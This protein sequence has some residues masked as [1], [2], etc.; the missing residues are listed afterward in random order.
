MSKLEIQ[1]EATFAGEW[2]LPSEDTSQ[3]KDIAG[4]LTWEEV[5]ARLELH[6]S[7]TP[8]RSGPIGGK[9]HRVLAIHG[10]TLKST[11]VSM[12]DAWC[13][14][15]SFSIGPGGFRTRDKFTGNL[16]VVGAHVG[17]HTLYSEVR[18]RIPALHLW[19]GP[20][21]MSQTFVDKTESTPIAV[22]VRYEGVAEEVIAVPEAECSIGWGL[23]R[24]SSGD[25]ASRIT[26]STSSCLRLHPDTPKPLDWFF[27]QA[28]SLSTL[29]SLMA[30]SA[31][32]PAEITAKTENNQDV[33]VLVSLLHNKVSEFD[34]QNDFF[35]RRDTLGISL[36]D[37]VRNWYAIYDE[38][39]L[40]AKF[41]VSILQ[42][43]DLWVN[44][45]FLSLMQAME[46]LHRAMW[47]SMANTKR[48]LSLRLAD[49]VGTLDEPLR[50]L[51]LKGD[52]VPDSWI[53]TR[54]YYTHWLEKLR[55]KILSGADIIYAC[56]RLRILLRVLFLKH[57]GV[58]QDFILKGFDTPNREVQYLRQLS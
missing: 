39:E 54:N 20:R 22:V 31:M 6:D 7:F 24:H 48:S 33:D 46:G 26:I 56:T 1:K 15:G 55:P 23:D 19:L 4:T 17:P 9:P 28:A 35:L 32:G 16:V 52:Q 2:H 18:M 11:L 53:K 10:T 30:G 44:A 36:E 40:P 27:T 49:L 34:S 47:P 12:L 14:S 57:I 50:R 43:K 25:M 51:I 41:S 58:P 38:I 42:S 3:V 29:L 8:I 13:Y 37:V 5:H 21:G 45:E